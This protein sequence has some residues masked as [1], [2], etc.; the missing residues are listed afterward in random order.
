MSLAS[1]IAKTIGVKVLPTA[2]ASYL[3]KR[4]EDKIDEEKSD[5]S[6]LTERLCQ[7]SNEELMVYVPDV[8]QKNIYDIDYTSLQDAGI[9]LVSFDI[10][11]TID[12][13]LI[14]NLQADV[15]I[16][17]FTV[18]GKAKEL[19]Q[20][21]KDK[22]FIVVLLTNGSDSLAKGAFKALKTADWYIAK[23]EKPSTKNFEALAKKYGLQP[24]EMAHIGNSICDDVAGGN[25]FGA[26]TCMIRRAGNSMKLG[27]LAQ[28]SLGLPTKGHLV[29]EELLKRDIWR[30]HHKSDEN[31]QYY[32]LGK[33]PLYRQKDV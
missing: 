15:A 26:T 27:K 28:A 24:S 23:A 29:R 21:L 30:K 14:N 18:P 22:G 32:Q 8:Y 12:D 7:M 31:D 25:Q 17:P 20:T 6:E 9:K 11:D 5:R 10:D 1:D 19:F 4:V 3:V 33:E 13:V 16:L 2:A